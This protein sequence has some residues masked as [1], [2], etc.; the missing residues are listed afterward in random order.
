MRIEPIPRGGVGF[1]YG[2]SMPEKGK[3]T[4]P[5]ALVKK[6]YKKVDEKLDAGD[7]KAIDDLV[8]LVKLEKEMGGEEKSVE[9]IRARWEPSAESSSEK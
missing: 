3:N 5:K 9:E 2:E 8:K 7:E 6:A 1:F 4:N